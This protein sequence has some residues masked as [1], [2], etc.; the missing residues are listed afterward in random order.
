[1]PISYSATDLRKKRRTNNILLGILA[2]FPVAFALPVN[3]LQVR[4]TPSS[5]HLGDTLSIIINP[6]NPASPS[7]TLKVASGENTYP[8]FEIS[9]NEYRALIPTTPLEKPGKRV[10][11][12]I[13]DG[14]E[15]NLLV[16]VHDRS[17][18]VQ[19]INLP[20]G[21]AGVDATE[22]ELKR[23]AALKALQTPEKYW[24]GVFIKP[25]TGSITTIYG[26]R[27]YYNGRFAKDYYHRGIDYAGAAGSPVVA[28]AG[29]RVALVGRVSQGFRVHGNVV[30]IDHG[31]GVTSIFMH[32]SHINVKEGDIVKPGQLIGTV[33]ST[34]ASTGPHLHWGLYVNGQ[35]VDPTPWKTQEFK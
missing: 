2:A 4:I 33:G 25:N 15:Q 14:K 5:P 16:L 6:D 7:T 18:P 20:P 3:A 27:R 11:R 10:I 19:R 1:M 29:G 12:V 32:L 24:D 26:V 17:F 22:Y 34:G 21:K 9:S 35:S 13:V 23:V 28:P 8:A 30:G 31:Q